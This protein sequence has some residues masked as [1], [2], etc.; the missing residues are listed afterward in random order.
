MLNNT[1]DNIN[2]LPFLKETRKKKRI[3]I[4]KEKKILKRER[5]STYRHQTS[6]TD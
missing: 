1:F 4:K 6:K 5:E 2:C 3:P